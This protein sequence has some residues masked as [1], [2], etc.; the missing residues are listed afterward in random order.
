[1]TG[2]PLHTVASAPQKSKAAL[3]GLLRTFGFL[4]NIAG[5][6]AGSPVLIDAFVPT[7][8]AVH[9]GTFTEAQIQ[10]VLLTNAVTNESEWPVAF[11]SFLALQANVSATDVDAIRNGG[12][13]ADPPLAALSSLA[14]AMIETRGRVDGATLAAFL[15]A[16]FTREQVLETITIVAA[17][18]MTNYTANVVMPPLEDAF[19]SHAWHR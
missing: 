7:F 13:P 8:T 12:V 3:E 4:P 10:T 18:T 9:A 15:G 19:Q 14:R 6:M 1:M 17:S 11:H 2:F 5:A 16:G